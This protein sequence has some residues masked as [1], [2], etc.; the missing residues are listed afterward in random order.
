MKKMIFKMLTNSSVKTTKRTKVSES[1]GTYLLENEYMVGEKEVKGTISLKS[2][3]IASVETV[4]F[5]AEKT[6]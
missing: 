2:H 4:D 3:A 5:E 6:E 1:D